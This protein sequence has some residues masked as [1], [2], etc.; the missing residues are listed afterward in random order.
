M[1]LLATVEDTAVDESPTAHKGIN[2]QD[3]VVMRAKLYKK[4]LLKTNSAILY[5]TLL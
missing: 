2:V 4:V 3:T 1:V 5:R